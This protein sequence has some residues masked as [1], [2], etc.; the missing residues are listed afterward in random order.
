V[1]LDGGNGQAVGMEPLVVT[2]N[3]PFL[4][5]D[6]SK[7]SVVI[8]IQRIAVFFVVMILY[9]EWRTHALQALRHCRSSAPI[10]EEG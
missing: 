3:Y 10:E 4:Q 1:L 6:I 5:T 7:P 8:F 9:Q 2:Y